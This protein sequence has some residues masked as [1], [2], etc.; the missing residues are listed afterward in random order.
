MEKWEYFSLLSVVI[1]IG[2][3][4]KRKKSFSLAKDESFDPN[5]DWESEGFQG[6]YASIR[7][8]RVVR[9]KDTNFWTTQDEELARLG[10]ASWELAGITPPVGLPSGGEYQRHTASR[11]YLIFK[12]PRSEEG[13]D[14]RP[15][16]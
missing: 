15:N 3:W 2:E 5:V 12:R 1:Q 14:G 4:D 10:E 13:K 16:P 9:S 11:Y 8:A 7:M 6:D